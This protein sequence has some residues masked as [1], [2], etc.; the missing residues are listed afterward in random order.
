MIKTLTKSLQEPQQLLGDWIQLCISAKLDPL[1]PLPII[2]CLWR[3]II[4]IHLAPSSHCWIKILVNARTMPPYAVYQS[5]PKLK[6][7]NNVA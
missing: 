1:F 7:L 4:M 6:L 5:L 3:D 2:K